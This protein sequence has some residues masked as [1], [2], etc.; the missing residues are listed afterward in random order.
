[1]AGRG[2]ERTLRTASTHRIVKTS[3]IPQLTPGW[4]ASA[5]EPTSR[6]LGPGWVLGR[7]REHDPGCGVLDK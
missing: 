1:V 5:G 3:S 4:P 2:V 7:A 6:T